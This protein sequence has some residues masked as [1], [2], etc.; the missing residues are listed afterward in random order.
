MKTFLII[1]L[2]T[3]LAYSRPA[4]SQTPA[5]ADSLSM[6]MIVH[7]GD[8]TMAVGDIDFKPTTQVIYKAVFV[9]NDTTGTSKLHIKMGATPGTSNYLDKAFVFDQGG[10]LADG[11]AYERTGKIVY[12]TLGTFTGITAYT[13]QLRVENEHGEL[14]APLNISQNN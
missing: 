7:P 12:L 9:L 2:I 14:S 6:I 3:A 13:V 8:Q 11:T 1:G 10:S 5:P 4:F